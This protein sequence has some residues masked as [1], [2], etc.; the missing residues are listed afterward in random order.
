M[1]DVFF[2]SQYRILWM[3]NIF[4]KKIHTDKRRMP[5]NEKRR[6]EYGKKKVLD[7][8]HN[9]AVILLHSTSKDNSVILDDLIKEIKKQGYEIRSL[10]DF[11]R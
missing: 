11:V 4:V 3:Q 9:G 5:K 7:N 6:E 10:N 1:A 8:L 2:F